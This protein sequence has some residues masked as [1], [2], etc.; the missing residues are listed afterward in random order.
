MSDSTEV[1]SIEDELDGLLV[2]LQKNPK[3]LSKSSSNKPTPPTVIE[4]ISSEENVLQYID[5]N[6]QKILSTTLDTLQN[7]AKDVGDDP[8]RVSALAKLMSSNGKILEILNK[9][10]LK[11]RD[12]RSK[13]ELQEEKI[14]QAKI[15]EIIDKNKS[16]ITGREEMFDYIFEKAKNEAI[17]V[18]EIEMKD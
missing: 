10:L 5:T 12:I 7:F 14:N 1:K 2:E 16:V 8:E 4:D 6:V 17:D 15:K 13:K 9:R 3:N 11:D 18:E